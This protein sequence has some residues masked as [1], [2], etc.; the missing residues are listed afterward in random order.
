MPFPP[1]KPEDEKKPAPGAPKPA[2]EKPAFGAPKPAAP[3]EKPTFGAK[4]AAAPG[5]KPAPGGPTKPAPAAKSSPSSS[6]PSKGKGGNSAPETP[7]QG[8]PERK[9]AEE[10]GKKEPEGDKQ[11]LPKEGNEAKKPAQEHPKGLPSLATMTKPDAEKAYREAGSPDAVM[12][13]MMT[14][15][16]NMAKMI[17]ANQAP[18]A[19]VGGANTQ[20][21]MGAAKAGG[22]PKPGV[23]PMGAK[24]GMPGRPAMPARPGMAGGMAGGMT[25]LPKQMSMEQINSMMAIV[26]AANAGRLPRQGAAHLLAQGFG[27]D[28]KTALSMVSPDAPTEGAMGSPLGQPGALPGAVPG[29]PA[30]GAELMN[31]EEEELEEG[32]EEEFEEEGEELEEGEPTAAAPAAPVDDDDDDDP[33]PEG[34][35]YNRLKKF[36]RADEWDEDAHP[37]DES[38]KFSSGGGGGGGEKKEGGG[39]RRGGA[40]DDK[41]AQTNMPAK[42]KEHRKEEREVKRAA[43]EAKERARAEVRREANRIKGQAALVKREA[44]RRKAQGEYAKNPDPKATRVPQAHENTPKQGADEYYKTNAHPDN[45]AKLKAP[46]VKSVEYLGGGVN[47]THKLKME[48]GSKATWKPAHGEAEYVRSNVPTGT[49][50]IREAAAANLARVIGVQDLVP[51]AVAY[52]GP[53]S[54]GSNQGTNGKG[55]DRG[56]MGVYNDH[57]PFG[58]SKPGESNE[59]SEARTAGV[60]GSMHAWVPGKTVS[61]MWGA[62]DF[63][64]DAAERA[65]AFDYI[66]GSSDRHGKNMVVNE[67]DGKQYP[68]LIDNGL[69]FPTSGLPDRHI[70][71][72]ATLKWDGLLDSTK[73]MIKNIEPKTVAKVLKQSGLDRPA[74]KL[75]LQRLH[76]L[77]SNPTHIATR[78]GTGPF[79]YGWRGEG[80]DDKRAEQQRRIDKYEAMAETT[81]SDY[82]DK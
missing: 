80:D 47:G 40:D 21:A 30:P 53:E 10:A 46:S 59:V 69:S 50:Y 19:P 81:I 7:N 1:K 57:G 16:E 9:Q 28:L 61:E 14:I 36:R 17:K 42:I 5:E 35:E 6:T 82:Y 20:Q 56:S 24:V 55:T 54:G 4:P 67:R 11:A 44:D 3:G 73:T 8:V 45:L 71:P 32:G 64:R 76:H 29:A 31:P 65:R 66:V 68:A 72:S 41:T 63:D 22:M 77:Q 51:A 37:R 13:Q 58:A 62:P 18:A 27:V 34:A 75:T 23:N 78:G 12:T 26:E 49:F 52:H 70:Q 39:S 33:G 74:A 79:L 60:K 38:G 48:D 43:K 15:I 2:G 25:A